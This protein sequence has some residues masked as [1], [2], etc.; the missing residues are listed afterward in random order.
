MRSL[1]QTTRRW[2]AKSDGSLDEKRHVIFWK[3]TRRFD[4]NKP[5]FLGCYWWLEQEGLR[6]FYL[7]GK[8]CFA[9]L[10]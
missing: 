3:T 9:P 8:A 4:E 6:A 7:R 5:S 2:F 1:G 10:R